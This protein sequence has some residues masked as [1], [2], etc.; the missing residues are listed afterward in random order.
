MRTMSYLPKK[1]LIAPLLLIALVLFSAVTMWLW[2][3][4]MPDLFKLPLLNYWQ[5]AGLLILARLFFGGARIG[6]RTHHHDS[7]HGLPWKSSIR[8]KVSKMTP[9]ERRDFFRKLHEY[10]HFVHYYDSGE[11]ETGKDEPKKE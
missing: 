10:R 7:L 3:A 1:L 11:K 2:N 4:L 5:A 6:A 8:E 9:E